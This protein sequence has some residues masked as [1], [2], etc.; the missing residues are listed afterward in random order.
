MV[1]FIEFF[2][3]K[4][5]RPVG[6]EPTSNGK[7]LN[8]F[9]ARLPTV[10]PLVLRRSEREPLI[11]E[12]GRKS[13]G[14]FSLFYDG[15]GDTLARGKGEKMIVQRE[16]ETRLQYLARV[17]YAFMQ[18][19]G[20]AAECTIDYDETTCDGSCLADDFLAELSIFEDEL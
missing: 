9:N 18:K 4:M 8:N 19:N 17:L 14:E 2:T 20:I 13:K 6:F 10:T 16:H 7:I 12:V 5:V 1:D 11:T 3:S 15:N